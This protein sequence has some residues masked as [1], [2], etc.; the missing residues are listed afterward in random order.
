MKDKIYWI[1]LEEIKIKV[2]QFILFFIGYFVF[3]MFLVYF[4]GKISD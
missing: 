3:I 4:D 2:L 1:R